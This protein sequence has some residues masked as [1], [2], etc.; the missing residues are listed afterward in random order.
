MFAKE[1]IFVPIDE[2]VILLIGILQEKNK[3]E[4]YPKI[5]DENKSNLNH[6]P[7][8]KLSLLRVFGSK[9]EMVF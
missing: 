6:K 9:A 5:K 8:V 3:L 7:L 4:S 1:V 2:T